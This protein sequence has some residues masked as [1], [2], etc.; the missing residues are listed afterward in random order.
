MQ[1]TIL[2]CIIFFLVV[3]ACYA[4]KAKSNKITNPTDQSTSDVLDLFFLVRSNDFLKE[5][6]TAEPCKETA[7]PNAATLTIRPGVGMEKLPIGTEFFIIDKD[8]KIIK[9]T[10]NK[11][12][13][14][15]ENI[16]GEDNLHYGLLLLD[17]KIDWK[18]DF[19]AAAPAVMGIKP[20]A[21]NL[22]TVQNLSPNASK[23]YQKRIKKE[24]KTKY[25]DVGYFDFDHA[26]RITIPGMQNR[27]EIIHVG[28]EK[29]YEKYTNLGDKAGSASFIF[30][31]KNNRFELIHW[32]YGNL[33]ILGITDMD[34][35]GIAELT[36]S[37]YASA[38]GDYSVLLFDGKKILNKQK[39]LYN[40]GH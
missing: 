9:G 31:T 16:F 38:G 4:E 36:V 8:N 39:V 25:P 26:Q 21:K 12:A 19:V 1:K 33:E 24:I 17:G 15:C 14:S 6:G 7:I 2:V 23:A 5:K 27:H 13:T 22:G 20:S 29:N 30:S 35:D 37:D 40:W 18:D 11:I 3:P 32:D 28:F 34:N 10:L